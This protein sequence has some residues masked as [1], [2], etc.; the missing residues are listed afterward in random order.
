MSH[1]ASPRGATW[2]VDNTVVVGWSRPTRVVCLGVA[3]CGFR[4]A[5]VFRRRRGRTHDGRGCPARPA[6]PGCRAG[7]AGRRD[8]DLLPQRSHDRPFG[9]TGRRGAPRRATLGRPHADRQ[10]LQGVQWRGR[11]AL[12]A[13]GP[14]GSGRHDRT[15]A[16][17][18]RCRQRGRRS[19]CA[20]CSTTP[21]DYPTTHSPT[22]SASRPP[23]TRAGTSRRRRS[24]T[25][26]AR[27]AWFSRRVRDTSTR[28]PTTSSSG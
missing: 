1:S 24:S 4:G 19:R 9:G 3:D 22:G 17:R 15:A 28:T 8:R 13:A 16:P 14:A 12:G 18:E 20:S 7:W 26:C 25:G 11:A 6:A 2:T 5:A 10:C 21:A 23:R 27:I